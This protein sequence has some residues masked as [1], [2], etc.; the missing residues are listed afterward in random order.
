MTCNFVT[1]IVSKISKYFIRNAWASGTV[2][3]DVNYLINRGVNTI[4]TKYN[5]FVTNFS[6]VCNVII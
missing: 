2:L 6:V 1:F 4:Q 5:L 3:R